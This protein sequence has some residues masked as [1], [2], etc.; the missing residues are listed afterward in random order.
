MRTLKYSKVISLFVSGDQLAD[1]DKY[2][3]SP[4]YSVAFW[5]GGKGLEGRGAEVGRRGRGFGRGVLG[6]SCTKVGDALA[7]YG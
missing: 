4:L 5:K 7:Q 3:S 2:L 1:F 6:G